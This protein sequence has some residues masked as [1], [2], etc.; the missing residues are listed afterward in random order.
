M[1]GENSCAILIAGT[2]SVSAEKINK[3]FANFAVAIDTAAEW[4]V[5]LFA[6]EITKCDENTRVC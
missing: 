5:N 2:R 6:L 4:T 1:S 3:I